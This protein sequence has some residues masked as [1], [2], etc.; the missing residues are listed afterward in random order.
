MRA[1]ERRGAAA[2]LI[3]LCLLALP[4][5]SSASTLLGRC[6]T[7]GI[8]VTWNATIE[9]NE[10]AVQHLL[11][12]RLPRGRLGRAAFEQLEASLLRGE[13][14]APGVVWW[15][16]GPD[17]TG[18]IAFAHKLWLSPGDRLPI[19]GVF[20]GGDWAV[21]DR[22]P[23]EDAQISVSTGAHVARSASG[24]LLVV[25]TSPMVL[26]I[27]VTTRDESGRTWVMRGDA[28]FERFREVVACS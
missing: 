10:Q 2:L 15:V 17:Q 19:S 12:S 1:V 13:R 7:E 8:Q 16:P 6:E 20:G 24:E 9:R 5:C 22:L 3:I 23:H 18:A 25:A 21:M 26:R 11:R 28:R 27:N 4:A 14:A